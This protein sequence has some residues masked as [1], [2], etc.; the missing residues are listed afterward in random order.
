METS[1]SSSSSSSSSLSKLRMT[2]T[3]RTTP[4]FEEINADLLQNILERLPVPSFASAT[5]VS[6]LWNRVC[7]RI[8]SRPKLASALSLNP[9]LHMAVE[10]VFDKVLSK[11]IRPHFALASIGSGFSLID[12]FR[13]ITKRLGLSTPLIVSTASGLI[14]RDAL[15]NEFREVKPDG[16]E[17]GTYVEDIDTGIVF[18][19]GYVPG[20]KVDAIPL[21]QT[22]KFVKDIKDYT[23][24]VSGCTSP[25]G[26]IIFGVSSSFCIFRPCIADYAMPEETVIVGDERGHFLYRSGNETRNV[27]GR[28]KPDA[29]ALTF[30]RDKDKSSGI[31]DIQFH[32]A[33][34]NGVSAVGPIYKAASVRVDIPENTT[35]LTARREG[36]MHVLD[37]QRILDDIYDEMENHT[38]ESPDLYIGVTKRRKYRIESD[39]TRLIT[40]L[41]LHGVIQGDEQYL[42]VNGVN[43]KT[44]DYF[45]FYHSDSNFA[46]SSSTD[47]YVNLKSLKKEVFGGL[48]FACCGRGESFFGRCNVDSSPF[49]DSFPGVPL[50]G[51]FCCGEIGRGSSSLIGESNKEKSAH[52]CMHV[53]STVYLAMSY[54]SACPEC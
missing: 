52:C 40:S 13:L 2:K 7:N 33:L 30:A 27:S 20:L 9:S 29:I 8:L 49:L 47:A 1:C 28:T 19:L 23:A 14:G 34:S 25:V 39:N 22:A 44:G 35:W 42:Y 54:S 50:A 48:I 46:L 37:G 24:S 31:G 51:I 4:R 17:V 53:F 41:A 26:I 15:T 11:P 12:A 5:C 10:E 36:D 16:D 6:K 38:D 45:Q 43:I 32:V 18:T 3:H 21:L